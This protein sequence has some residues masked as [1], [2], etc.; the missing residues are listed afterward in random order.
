MAPR[1]GNT[2]PSWAWFI[3]SSATRDLATMA[4]SRDLHRTDPTS[5][6]SWFGDDFQH[7]DE[8]RSE[9]FHQ[10]RIPSGL[11]NPVIAFPT[12]GAN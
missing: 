7:G 10:Q 4:T 2:T 3:V 1:A 9:R 11:Q 6:I 8:M 5:L 12:D